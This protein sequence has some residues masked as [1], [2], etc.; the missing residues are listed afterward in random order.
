[1][2]NIYIYVIKFKRMCE[3]KQKLFV[4]KELEKFR[5]R[6]NALLMENIEYLHPGAFRYVVS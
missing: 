1:M 5:D 6:Y 2:Y 3:E 4:Q